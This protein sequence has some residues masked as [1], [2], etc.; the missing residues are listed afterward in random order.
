MEAQG[1]VISTQY[2]GA[3]KRQVHGCFAVNA[4]PGGL[5]ATYMYVEMTLRCQSAQHGAMPVSLQYRW[6]TSYS[7][8]NV[9]VIDLCCCYSH[10][11]CDTSVTV[12][13]R[14]P[15]QILK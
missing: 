14:V 1:W 7:K 8:N 4:R 6:A 13:V 3:V 11:N 12:H 15:S 9:S 10:A 2:S 5:G